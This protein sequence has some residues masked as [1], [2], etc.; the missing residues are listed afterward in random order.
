MLEKHKRKIDSPSMFEKRLKP[1]PRQSLSCGHH[2][3]CPSLPKRLF[4]HWLAGCLAHS[5][6][7][8]QIKSK[9]PE[10]GIIA[11]NLFHFDGLDQ[12][13]REG[14]WTNLRTTEVLALWGKALRHLS[15]RPL[16]IT[17]LRITV[18]CFNATNACWKWRWLSGC[19]MPSKMIPVQKFRGPMLWR[20]ETVV[21]NYQ[22]DYLLPLTG[23]HGHL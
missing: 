20:P 18:L 12:Q 8:P 3:L 13:I 10:K 11:N 15:W 9:T 4:F 16:G 6:K 22:H 5:D 17:N 7:A 2:V 14:T 23:S 21:M 19:T 1:R